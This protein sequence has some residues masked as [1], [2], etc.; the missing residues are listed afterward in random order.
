MWQ[1]KKLEW[2]VRHIDLNLINTFGRWTM[3]VQIYAAIYQSGVE[4]FTR[5]VEIVV[6]QK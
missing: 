4:S 6:E 5:R 3:I 2:P 1:C